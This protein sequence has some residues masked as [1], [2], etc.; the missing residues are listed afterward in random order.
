MAVPI[1][2]SH[3]YS[4][5]IHHIST[6]VSMITSCTKLNDMYHVS[7]QH[8][9]VGMGWGCVAIIQGWLFEHAFMQLLFE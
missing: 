7:V 3:T 1:T 2:A 4:H 8:L 9:G 6:L 5:H